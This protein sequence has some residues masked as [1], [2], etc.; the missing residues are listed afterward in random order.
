[1][2]RVPKQIDNPAR[3]YFL[4]V[5]AMVLIPVLG[6][7]GLLLG[8]SH[9]GSLAP[10][11]LTGSISFDLKVEF[12]REK[13]PGSCKVLAIGSSMSL[14]NLDSEVIVRRLGVEDQFLNAGAWGRRIGQTR[15][16]LELLLEKY[17]PHMVILATAPIDFIEAE[18]VDYDRGHLERFIKGSPYWI[19]VARY[20][21][22][23]YYYDQRKEMLKIKRRRDIFTS[24]Q[25]DEYGGVVFNV[26]RESDP[27]WEKRYSEA[28]ALNEKSPR[29]YEQ[30]GVIADLLRE[31][32]IELV[33]VQP[34]IRGEAF[35]IQ[36][37]AILQ[38]WQQLQ[39]VVA[40]HQIRFVNLHEQLPVSDECFSDAVHFNSKGVR[41]FTTALMDFVQQ[42]KQP[43]EPIVRS[44]SSLKLDSP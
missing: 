44:A 34:P 19:T 16:F 41:L 24:L 43:L 20:F 8:A 25:F 31:R 37:Q 40:A 14:N 15:A 10:P 11:P 30:L 38:H 9:E 18:D 3:Q 12:L 2:K 4:V 5:V 23:K 27:S 7:V 17:D 36:K 39:E 1:M 29:Q 33:V 13:D 21:N 35:E 22:P 6:I 32:E 42:D 26:T 28:Y